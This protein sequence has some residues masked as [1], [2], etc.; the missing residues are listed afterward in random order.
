MKPRLIVLPA[1]T[2]ERPLRLVEYLWNR[3]P[4]NEGLQV[5]HYSQTLDEKVRPSH[6]RSIWAGRAE[7]QTVTHRQGWLVGCPLGVIAGVLVAVIAG[8]TDGVAACTSGAG[9]RGAP[10]GRSGTDTSTNVQATRS[11]R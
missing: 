3:A 9:N 5:F 1:T 8:V 7:C 11:A 10:S 2:I 6:L 4:E